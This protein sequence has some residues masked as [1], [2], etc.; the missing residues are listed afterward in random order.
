M[1]KA[2]VVYNLRMLIKAAKQNGP[3][4]YEGK[5][6]I[7]TAPVAMFIQHNVN[8]PLN[9]SEARHILYSDGQTARL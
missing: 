9:L 2:G 7:C 3:Y 4:A 6:R 5:G 1:N 8:W